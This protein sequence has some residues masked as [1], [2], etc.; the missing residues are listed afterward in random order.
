MPDTIQSAAEAQGTERDGMKLTV[1]DLA[2][3]MD[4]SAVRT[5][6]D[7]AE[8]RELAAQ[9]RQRHCICIFPMPCYVPLCKEL[10]AGCPDVGLGGVVGFPSGAVATTTKVGEARQLIADGA[11]EL[12]MVINVGML[13]SGRHDYVRDDIK[14][15]VQ[16]AGGTPV[17]V[18]LE[19]H[20]LND[21]QIKKGS[22][23]C[24]RA[25]AAFVK[26]GTGCTETGATT[27]NVSLIK[28]TIGNEA[29]IKAAGGVRDLKT[30]VALYRCG[31]TRFGISHKSGAKIL[32][33]CAALAGGAVEV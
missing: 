29:K 28:A 8:I 16:A 5:D 14:A 12:D 20:Y 9:A 13:R 17:K 6:V 22:E 4:F 25:G 11:V 2:R 3:M 24:V 21:E 18:I 1:H 10:L 19:V 23:L 27:H 33:E 31:A 15:V 7:E 26:T 32:D 30:L